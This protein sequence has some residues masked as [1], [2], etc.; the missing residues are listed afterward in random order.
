MM[1]RTELALHEGRLGLGLHARELD[2]LGGLHHLH[3]V[4]PGEKIEMPIGT[5]EFAVGD[6]TQ[7]DLFLPGDDLPDL[8][9]LDRFEFG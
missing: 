6:G 8:G 5:P 9:I 3:A 7:A 1:P 2:A 4:E